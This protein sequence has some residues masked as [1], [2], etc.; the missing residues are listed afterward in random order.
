MKQG[1]S[2]IVYL[3]SIASCCQWSTFVK[4]IRHQ[5]RC[6]SINF[7]Y[8]FVDHPFPKMQFW[9]CIRD[10]TSLLE[11]SVHSS[12]LGWYKGCIFQSHVF[13]QGRN[14]I[15]ATLHTRIS[16]GSVSIPSLMRIR[17]WSTI[18]IEVFTMNSKG[19]FIKLESLIRP[20]SSFTNVESYHT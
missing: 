6:W 9:C 7:S 19:T 1:Q 17:E 13:L 11:T 12:N 4:T 18:C 14:N 8:L 10:P 15:H 20:Y 2:Q 16:H 3:Y 5:V